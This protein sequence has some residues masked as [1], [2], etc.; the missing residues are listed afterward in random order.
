MQDGAF[1]RERWR[2]HIREEVEGYEVVVFAVVDC[3][4]SYLMKMEVVDARNPAAEPR[5]AVFGCCKLSM[6]RVRKGDEEEHQHQ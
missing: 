3:I 5:W 2:E 4:A 6:M 1:R